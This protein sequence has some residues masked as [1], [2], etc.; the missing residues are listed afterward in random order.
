MINKIRE[1]IEEHRTLTSGVTTALFL[2]QLIHLY[3]MFTHIILFRL[4]GVSYFN[5]SPL[6]NTLLALADYTEIPA[7][8]SG[9]LLYLSHIKTGLTKKDWLFLFLLNSQW[10]HLFW[11]TDEV[12]YNQF[13]GQ[14]AFYIPT[15]L[16]WLAIVVDYF[17][18]PVIFDTGK[19]F[20]LSLRGVKRRG[21][22]S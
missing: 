3:W 9:T 18:L 7:L 11:I 2:T 20:I 14:V 10:L 4:T 5:P 19:E 12:I 1:W 17:E 13:T 15:W 6:F 22:L 21:D 16:S 8:I